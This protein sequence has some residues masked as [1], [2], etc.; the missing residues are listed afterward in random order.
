[1]FLFLMTFEFLSVK[2]SIVFL[3]VTYRNIHYRYMYRHDVTKHTSITVLSFLI[4]YRYGYTRKA[5]H[6]LVY[7]IMWFDQLPVQTKY[8]LLFSF[9]FA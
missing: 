1:M 3:H 7:M 9:V 8:Y 2:N 6:F 5:I 4:L